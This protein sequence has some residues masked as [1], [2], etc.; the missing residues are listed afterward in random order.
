MCLFFVLCVGAL[1]IFRGQL[2]S[3]AAISGDS[4]A[5]DVS[6]KLM[7]PKN[8][9]KLSQSPAAYC[10]ACMSEY[11][12]GT[13]SNP[14][15][16][17]HRTDG[18]C[19]LHAPTPERH[20]ASPHT[21]LTSK[22]PPKKLPK[23]SKSPSSYCPLCMREYRKGT[24]LYPKRR[25][26]RTDGLCEPHAPTP[27][28]LCASPRMRLASKKSPQKL[29]KLSE[30]PFHYCPACM[31]EYRTGK[32]GNPTRRSHRTDGLCESHAPTP[33]RLLASPRTRLAIK[34]PP[35]KLPKLAQSPAAY[36]CAEEPARLGG[37]HLLVYIYIYF[38]SN[39]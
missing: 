30:S 16:R 18:L 17:S 29:P 3:V 39:L 31:S 12:A 28:R 32:N 5:P 37:H 20:L 7:P 22:K 19:E 27:A 14:T 24:N 9:P 15:R 2:C 4:W 23:L 13:N 8:A 6:V 10:S 1:C 36:T 21:R 26:H 35:Q 38:L 34:K 25:S 33:E 11:W